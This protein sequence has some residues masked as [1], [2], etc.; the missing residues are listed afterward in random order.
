MRK[1]VEYMPPF[2]KDVREL[3]RIFEAEDI[4]IE[5]INKQLELLLEEVTVITAKDFGLKRYEKIYEISN[6]ADSIEA[7]RNNI[8]FRMNFKTPYSYFWLINILDSVIGTENYIIKLD[9]KNYI[10]TIEVIELYKDIT[11]ELERVLRK[12]LPANLELNIN[13]CQ[14]EEMN[15]KYIA[16][17]VHQ[18]DF[19][20]IKQE[21]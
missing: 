8:L 11:K 19:M 1:L 12:E 3:N 9:Y 16:G 5:R 7:R 13:I 6:V 21:V 15:N 18:A 14:T 10:L 2:L 17:V 4:E 20:K